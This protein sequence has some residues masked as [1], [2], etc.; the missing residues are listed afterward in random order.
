MKRALI[1]GVFGQDGSYLA[2]LLAERGY[3]VH[4][5]AR[6]KPSAVSRD[7]RAHLARKNVLPTV[8]ACDLLEHAEVASL[9]GTVRPDECYHLAAVHYSSQVLPAEQARRDRDL[10]EHNTNSTLNLL[11]AVREH[12]P[13]TRFLLAGSCLM[14]DASPHSPQNESMPYSS[15]SLYGLSKI[16]GD[17]LVEYFRRND[18]HAS[19][20][21]LYNH[22][23]PR[24]RPEF[25]TRKIVQGLVAVKQ[26]RAPHLELGNLSGVKDWGYAPD[27]V[28]GMWQMAMAESPSSRILATGVAHTVED[29]VREAAD[30][31][32]YADY[33][34][35]V[36]V[37]TG[38]ARPS[39]A[40]PLI[41]DAT[42]ARTELDW[43]PVVTFRQ[44]IEKM[45][46]CELS[47]SLD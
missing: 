41:G 8:H 4:G 35:V 32:G 43:R 23:S 21:I 6:A 11:S 30:V 27:Y 2:E 34:E 16:A 5:V 24:R 14:Y 1:T 3:E 33:R 10:Y 15:R 45:I 46:E 36:R 9:I 38:L 47:G 26:G 37:G 13:T 19:T 20:A 25:V 22:E 40:V 39:D 29:F 17:R 12:S 7:T 28:R 42:R 31:L 18:V 44:M